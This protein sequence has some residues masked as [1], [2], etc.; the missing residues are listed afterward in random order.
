MR[1]Y[2]LCFLTI[3]FWSTANAEAVRLSNPIVQDDNTETFGMKLNEDLPSVSLLQLL[4]SPKQFVENKFKLSTEITKVC[5]KKGCFFIARENENVI[6]ITLR[7]YSFFIPTD[8]SGKTITLT[9]N[10]VQKQIS[11]KQA[12]HFNSDLQDRN[13]P[14]QVGRVYEIVADSV[15]IPKTS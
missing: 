5:Q 12:D 7:D 1:K 4:S 10:L 13:N 3:V 9:G 8:S 6:R 2:L 15:R 11:Q 14:I